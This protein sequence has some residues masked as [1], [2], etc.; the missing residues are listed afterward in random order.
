M[1]ELRHLFSSH[2]RNEALFARSVGHS[3][4]SSFSALVDVFNEQ[5]AVVQYDGSLHNDVRLRNQAVSE[6]EVPASKAERN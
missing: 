3:L 2:I 5:R 4:F 1:T 6:T